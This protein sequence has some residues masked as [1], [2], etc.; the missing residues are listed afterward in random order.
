MIAVKLFTYFMPF[1]ANS[2]LRLIAIPITTYVLGPREYGLFALMMGLVNI[3]TVLATSV[4][5]YVINHRAHPGETA[6]EGLIV[7]LAVLEILVGLIL[8]VVCM[9]LWPWFARWMGIVGDAPYLNFL[10]LLLS[11][12]LGAFW[13]SGSMMIVFDDRA[14]LYSGT[15]IAQGA[16]QLVATIVALYCF[17]W[18]VGSLVAGQVMGVATC[19]VGG[20][21]GLR[22]HFSVG[23]DRSIV[24]E[25]LA[26]MPWSI[27]SGFA[28]SSTDLLERVVLGRVT[29]TFQ[30]G[31]YV[32]SQSYRTM[33]AQAGKA[34]YQILQPAMLIEARSEKLDFSETRR[35][36]NVVFAMVSLM[37]VGFALVGQEIISWLTHGKFA[38]AAIYVPF[39]CIYLLLLYI[40]RPQVA[41]LYAHG[42]GKKIS[43]A[44][45]A[46]N[47]VS[48]LLML[49][50]GIPFH[51]FGLVAAV[52]AGELVNRI[53]L[54]YWT[55]RI[56]SIGFHDG[57]A[58]AGATIVALAAGLTRFVA[59]PFMVRFA[60]F[61]GMSAMIFV[62]FGPTAYK[63]LIRRH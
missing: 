27:L 4:T 10:A 44:S 8:T 39:W 57:Y 62:F 41:M 29:N 1:V 2:L 35:G 24:R 14:V 43:S 16:I 28:N 53:V 13:T 17:H 32:H 52:I 54:Q 45:L 20:Y 40:G 3:C 47:L 22:R 49:A 48:G 6:P 61:V 51:A 31:L 7:T 30:L 33:L 18:R 34:F 25:S 19:A 37:G 26:L 5:G 42:Q 46:G 11:V 56:W 55:Y 50:L 60:T 63:F 9:G 36:W 21:L 59:I 15:L 23:L 38:A 12:P 58:L